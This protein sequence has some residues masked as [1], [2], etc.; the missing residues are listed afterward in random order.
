MLFDDKIINFL[1]INDSLSIH[2]V[3]HIIYIALLR[4]CMFQSINFTFHSVYI[5]S[6][7]ILNENSLVN[8]L[9]IT[10]VK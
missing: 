8:L 2:L 9:V 1:L 6:M 5:V 4:I 3:L 10:I 7:K